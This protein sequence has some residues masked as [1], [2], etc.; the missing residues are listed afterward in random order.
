MLHVSENQMCTYST[1]ACSFVLLVFFLCRFQLSFLF[2]IG[3]DVLLD[4]VYVAIHL[5]FLDLFI[6]GKITY[7]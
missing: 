1:F 5:A 7:L 4:A 3:S 6:C 2:I